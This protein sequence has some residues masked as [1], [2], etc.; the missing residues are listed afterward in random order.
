MGMRPVN[1]RR[2]H[3]APDVDKRIG[4]AYPIVKAVYESLQEIRYLAHN[5][6]RLRPRD[7]EIRANDVDRQIE[8]RYVGEV[9]W[10]ILLPYNELLGVDI[11]ELVES[12]TALREELE[13]IQ[14]IV[15]EARDQTQ[16]YM[17]AAEQAAIDASNASRLEVGTV[18]TG[19]SGSDVIV[20]IVGSA[21]NQQINFTIPRGDVG[22]INELA[23]GTVEEGD[24]ASATITGT[25]PD[26]VL[27]LVL[28]RGDDGLTP[29]FTV[30]SV[31]T[32]EPGTA[33][34]V[35][36]TGTAPNFVL[37]ITIPRG[38]P[39]QGDGDMLYAENL[40]GLTD[41]AA[42][43]T[44]L[45]LGNV[46]NTSDANKPLS[47]AAIT[48]FADIDSAFTAV[49]LVLDEK[50]DKV[51]GMTLS[52]NN[53]TTVLL[54][55]LNGIATNATANATDAALRA[56]S[57][58]T[59]TQ[60]QSTIVN[61]VSDLASKAGTD[62]IGQVGGIASLDGNGKVPLSQI[63]EALIGAMK[64]QGL[65]N[66]ATN[67]PAIPAASSANLG[68]FLI[69]SV[70]GTTTIDGISDWAGG[71]WIVSIG[72]S[73]AKIDSSDQVTSVAGLIGNITTAALLAALGLQN[74]TNTSDAD[75]PVS[76]AQAAALALKADLAAPTFTG[77][78]KAVTAAAGDADTSIATTLFADRVSNGLTSVSIAGT[79]T[80][81]LTAANV[82]T[83]LLDLTGVLTGDKIITFPVKA[84]KWVVTNKV[85]GTFTTTLKTITG[86][87][88]ILIAQGERINVISDGVNLYKVGGGTGSGV[89]DGVFLVV[90]K[91]ITTDRVI[92]DGK[93]HVVFGPT[94]INANIQVDDGE[95][96]WT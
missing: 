17:Q 81:A 60:A 16:Q 90:E 94:E 35:L 3:K 84:G 49:D 29:V 70:A 2:N 7:I 65:W 40:S 79:G 48:A 28:P 85:T 22:P 25:Y 47:D 53:F 26:Q 37:E 54:N 95:L 39:G 19:A 78:A 86:S 88:T 11:P 38:N 52:E 45:E 55:K 71:D 36:I 74:V 62:L 59:G 32:G 20:S 91:S 18:T 80:Q 8:W 5:L 68:H 43:R 15:L 73:W 76:T 21:G 34:E 82:G 24:D 67:T 10:T 12:L 66:A 31:T 72:T 50:V 63:N 23:I 13:G 41:K 96:Y 42:A 30:G 69:V 6:T 83:G 9:E 61:L 14:V 89:E 27:N 44:N 75:K 1:D 64:F 4:D 46:N 33:A 58:H 77:D 57:S 93:R 51:N 87:E 56:R 92:N